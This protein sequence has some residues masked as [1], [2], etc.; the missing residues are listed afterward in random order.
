M[1]K[2]LIRIR[3]VTVVAW[4]EGVA[5]VLCRLSASEEQEAQE[6][7]RRGDGERVASICKG[8]ERITLAIEYE[9]QALEWSK[10]TSES[11]EGSHMETAG[12][13][14]REERR[15]RLENEWIKASNR[16]ELRR[17]E[18]ERMRCEWNELHGCQAI[19]EAE[20][21]RSFDEEAERLFPRRCQNEMTKKIVNRE[22][23]E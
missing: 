10:A 4:Q 22:R 13:E 15:Q 11:E 12:E 1:S 18:A 8:A 5:R 3:G 17:E 7:I 21:R 19:E 2:H 16:E 20:Y 9:R 14:R 23:L 6:A